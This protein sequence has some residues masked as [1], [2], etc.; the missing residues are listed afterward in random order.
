MWL[1]L[2]EGIAVRGLQGLLKM[3]GMYN[4]RKKRGEEANEYNVCPPK[5]R[6]IM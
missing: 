6:E 5:R 4:E 3:G 2:K 1:S